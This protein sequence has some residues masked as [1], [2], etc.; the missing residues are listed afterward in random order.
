MRRQILG[1]VVF[2]ALLLTLSNLLSEGFVKLTDVSAALVAVLVGGMAS[3]LVYSFTDWFQRLF[4]VVAISEKS[5]VDPRAIE[6]AN[7]RST[8]L[9]R[10][11]GDLVVH[12]GGVIE[13]MDQ[14]WD[15]QPTNKGEQV[16]KKGTAPGQT[17]ALWGLSSSSQKPENL[18]EDKKNLKPFREAWEL[19]SEGPTIFAEAERV[20][21]Q[22]RRLIMKYLTNNQNE[23][24]PPGRLLEKL[25]NNILDKLEARERFQHAPDF[26]GNM[27]GVHTQGNPEVKM[28]AVDLEILDELW[29]PNPEW[30]LEKAKKLAAIMNDTV[31]KEDVKD[32][33]RKRKAAWSAV[34][35]N[36]NDFIAAKAHLAQRAK[37]VQLSHS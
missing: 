30:T 32:M 9:E 19:Y 31:N 27:M 3:T 22:T 24:L 12:H 2:I 16:F 21:E 10:V 36:R 14:L 28:P 13:R 18:D 23:V 5:S 33:I 26:E 20:E 6:R 34:T 17:F 37:S 25:T 29:T 15:Y 7:I 4:G 8:E 35:K 11:T 1:L